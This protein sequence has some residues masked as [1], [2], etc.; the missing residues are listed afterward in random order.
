MSII[1]NL[2]QFTTS[3][4]GLMAIG[5]FSTLIITVGY[6]VLIKPDLERKTRQEAEAIADYIFQREVQRNSKKPDTF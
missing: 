2:K 5:I 3:S 1:N 6:R 4:A